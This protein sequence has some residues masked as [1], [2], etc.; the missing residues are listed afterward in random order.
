MACCASPLPVPVYLNTPQ[1]YLSMRINQQQV[2]HAASLHT[3][4]Y[5]LSRGRAALSDQEIPTTG[6]EWLRLLS[7]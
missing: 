2:A 1:L 4:E 3:T 6:E 5:I 7:S